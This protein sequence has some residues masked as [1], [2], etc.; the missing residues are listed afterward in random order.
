MWPARRPNNFRMPRKQKR[1]ELSLSPHCIISAPA[2]CLA[3][4]TFVTGGRHH[5]DCS[6]RTSCRTTFVSQLPA[7]PDAAL[8][9]GLSTRVLRPALRLPPLAGPSVQRPCFRSYAA[10]PCSPL[11]SACV[12]A[13]FGPGRG[14]RFPVH[15][16]ALSKASFP[17]PHVKIKRLIRFACKAF[18][19]IIHTRDDGKEPGGTFARYPALLLGKASHS[20]RAGSHL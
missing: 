6:R 5:S 9:L 20:G 3:F 17:G 19:K 10:P 4:R 7:P 14:Q 16:G 2:L 11:S 18:W 8:R 13:G 12:S 1:R 15:Y